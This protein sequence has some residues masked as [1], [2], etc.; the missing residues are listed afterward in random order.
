MI[1]VSFMQTTRL[2]YYCKYR[3]DRYFRKPPELQQTPLRRKKD[4]NA[5]KLKNWGL[6]SKSK[7]CKTKLIAKRLTF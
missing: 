4:F 5:R 7:Q 6:L 1:K 2:L 3:L